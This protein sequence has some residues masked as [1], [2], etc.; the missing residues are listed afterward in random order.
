M[1]ADDQR[2]RAGVVEPGRDECAAA[3]HDRIGGNL[4][5]VIV[6]PLLT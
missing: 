3:D 6:V 2:I 4:P 1:K 5:T